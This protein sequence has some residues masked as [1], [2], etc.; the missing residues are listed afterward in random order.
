MS[1][2]R[3]DGVDRIRATSEPLRRA[4]LHEAIGH[5]A[6]ARPWQQETSGEAARDRARRL[7]CSR[8]GDPD[9]RQQHTQHA[10]DASRLVA[11]L[12]CVASSYAATRATQ[13]SPIRRCTLTIRRVGGS[14]CEVKNLRPPFRM[15]SNFDPL[16]ETLRPH[17][18]V[19]WP[20]AGTDW[21]RR[22]DHGGLV[23]VDGRVR[24]PCFFA[25]KN[26]TAKR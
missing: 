16:R 7:L 6:H 23:R 25:V 3:H 20:A 26:E 17:A 11:R 24:R 1:V 15:V 2:R 10:G 5:D 12:V 19:R 14:R 4:L 18:S 22:R 21:Q 8:H 9:G 13:K